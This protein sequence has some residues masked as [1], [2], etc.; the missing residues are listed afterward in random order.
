MTR[1]KEA[2][3]KSSQLPDTGHTHRH[4]ARPPGTLTAL[5]GGAVWLFV[6]AP[7]CDEFGPRVYT[8]QRHAVDPGCLEAYAPIGLVEARAVSALCEPVCLSLGEGL[9][10]S[11]LCPPYPAEASVEP[12]D[13][14]GCTA[15]LA[16][17]LCDDPIETPDAAAP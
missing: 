12:E 7:A 16:A 2:T 17:P 13:S 3:M 9:Y 10:V 8:A 15:A 6:L 11:T 14:E 4:G 5:L 1:L